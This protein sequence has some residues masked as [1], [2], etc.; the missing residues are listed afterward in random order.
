MDSAEIP[1]KF[2]YWLKITKKSLKR[3]EIRANTH[4]LKRSKKENIIK[5]SLLKEKM[6]FDHK[7]VQIDFAILIFEKSNVY[8]TLN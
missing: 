5:T 4:F 2:R 3:E 6:T 8:Y 7:N 1:L